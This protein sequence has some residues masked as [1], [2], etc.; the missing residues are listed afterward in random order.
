VQ[1]AFEHYARGCMIQFLR[2][3]CAR[4]QPRLLLQAGLGVVLV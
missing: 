1:K 4:E 3:S 2:S